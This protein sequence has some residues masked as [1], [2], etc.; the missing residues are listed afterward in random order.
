MQISSQKGWRRFA[1]G[2]F[3]PGVLGSMIFDLGDP[4]RS[5][6]FKNSIEKL[7]YLGLIA[8][9]L[10]FC[11]DYFHLN[12]DLPSKTIL[13]EEL[14][15][16]RAYIK[17][18]SSSYKICIDILIAFFF[19]VSYFA[20]ARVTRLYS[21]DESIFKIFTSCM[22]GFSALGASYS[23]I[24][25]YEICFDSLK[26]FTAWVRLSPLFPLIAAIILLPFHME[27]SIYYIVY[28]PFSSLL[29]YI[30]YVFIFY[31]RIE[32]RINH[33]NQTID[34]NNK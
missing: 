11:I 17:L 31:R 26:H 25:L 13:K 28:F 32:I 27:R 5:L 8:I 34:I 33:Q 7:Q 16:P 20:I 3:Y 19:A 23:L 22:V 10:S 29:L 24:F 18:S 30:L 14:S 21:D 1:Y 9:V 12:V 4:L 15:I 2:L 6:P